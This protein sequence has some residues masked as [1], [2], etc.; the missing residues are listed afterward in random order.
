MNTD[1][2]TYIIPTLNTSKRMK[3]YLAEYLASTNETLYQVYSNYSTAK[4][5]AYIGCK[6]VMRDNLGHTPRIIT[7]NT[8]LFTFGF[9]AVDVDNVPNF[10]V[11]TPTKFMYMPLDTISI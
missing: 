8:F 2:S 11:I 1:N 10:Y 3:R 5:I 4:E 6:S 9:I 7:H